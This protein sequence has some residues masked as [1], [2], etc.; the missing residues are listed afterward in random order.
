[1][2]AIGADVVVD[3]VDM[4]LDHIVATV[5]ATAVAVMIEA[6]LYLAPLAEPH[7]AV[8]SSGIVVQWFGTYSCR[9]GLCFLL[10]ATSK[11]HV[12]QREQK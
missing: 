3:T 6:R 4:M 11:H 1:M 5:S 9:G 2:E 10:A 7:R 8:F 12:E